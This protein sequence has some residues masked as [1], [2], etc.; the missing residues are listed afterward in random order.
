[1]PRQYIPPNSHIVMPSRTVDSRQ[2]P[3][4]RLICGPLIYKSILWCRLNYCND[5]L[6][7]GNWLLPNTDKLLKIYRTSPSRFVTSKIFENLPA[8]VTNAEQLA[9]VVLNARLDWIEI[10]FCSVP[11]DYTHGED[12]TGSSKTPLS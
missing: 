9:T 3:S 11:S 4:S 8:G 5:T 1:M 7:R 10:R 6:W 2:V 12:T